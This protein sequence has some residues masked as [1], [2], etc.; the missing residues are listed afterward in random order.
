MFAGKCSEAHQ[1]WLYGLR[2]SCA[3]PLQTRRHSCQCDHARYR[4]CSGRGGRHLSDSSIHAWIG[5]VGGQLCCFRHYHGAGLRVLHAL[6]LAGAN[7]SAACVP[8]A[9]PL[10]NLP[11]DCGHLHAVH[12]GCAARAFRLGRSSAWSG[13]WPSPEWSSRALP[14]TGLPWRRHWS[15]CFRAGL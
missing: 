7:A 12:A 14:W 13:R 1:D 15:T 10:F 9:R 11:A 6:P 5:S 8:R 2:S 3:N 4:S